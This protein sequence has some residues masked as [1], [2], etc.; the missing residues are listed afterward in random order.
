MQKCL[1]GARDTLREANHSRSQL[2]ENLGSLAI[3]I[4]L[5]FVLLHKNIAGCANLFPGPIG[6]GTAGLAWAVWS[7]NVGQE[8]AFLSVV[9]LTNYPVGE[10]LQAAT[11]VASLVLLGSLELLSQVVSIPCAYT[12]LAIS[13]LSLG[14]WATQALVKYLSNDYYVSLLAGTVISF[15]A[16]ATYKLQDHIAWTLVGTLSAVILLTYQFVETRRLL[17]GLLLGLLVSTAFFIDWYLAYGFLL[18]YFTAM[19]ATLIVHPQVH[20][21]IGN[22]LFL[23][24][25]PLLPVLGVLT[26]Q[27]AWIRET[28]GSLTRALPERTRSELDA[29]AASLDQWILPGRQTLETHTENLTTFTGPMPSWIREFLTDSN[30]NELFVGTFGLFGF[31]ILLWA[32][33]D[34]W[35][36]TAPKLLPIAAVGLVGILFSSQSSYTLFGLNILSPSG[37]VFEFMPA[38]R[39]VDRLGTL[40]VLALVI[41]GALGFSVARRRSPTFAVRC[42]FTVAATLTV[43]F[44]IGFPTGHTPR[45]TDLGN[46]PAPY[47]WLASRAS[48]GSETPV[49]DLVMVDDVDHKYATWQ[50]AYALPLVNARRP[51]SQNWSLI[52]G[53]VESITHPQ[54]ACI[55][56]TVGSPFILHHW[57]ETP[58]EPSS[59]LSLEKSFRSSPGEVDSDDR[60]ELETWDNVDIYRTVDP[61]VTSLGFMAFGN[62]WS[63]GGWDGSRGISSTSHRDST[64]LIRSTAEGGGQETYNIDARTDRDSELVRITQNGHAVWSGSITQDWQRIKFIAEPGVLEVSR[65]GSLAKDVGQNLWIGRFGA[66]DCE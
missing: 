63:R 54:L 42:F 61:L 20:G 27:L 34:R 47:A 6:D 50:M 49:A 3:Y 18:V 43:L 25:A 62:G 65:I 55:A 58:L 7:R 60:V 56:N 21:R 8:N 48:A 2:L 15:G 59:L 26:F 33:R 32:L 52:N 30:T 17:Y 4:S 24:V 29:Y 14:A 10:D 64:L 35:R 66:G 41:F 39:S 13:F 57:S 44:D 11:D 9:P 5:G 16:F 28:S 36:V 51:D 23:L 46:V 22:W 1:V 12:L 31:L 40:T 37:L 53:M 38:V 45:I 19:P